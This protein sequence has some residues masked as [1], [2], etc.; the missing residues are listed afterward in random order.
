MPGTGYS[1]YTSFVELGG[2]RVKLDEVRSA[3]AKLPL[4]RVL[5]FLSHLSWSIANQG[6]RIVDPRW[7]APLLNMAIVDDFPTVLPSCAT[8]IAPG[9]VPFTG[10]SNVFIH[11][12]NTAT[13]SHLALLYCEDSSEG[14]NLA[15]S[16]MQ[17]VCRL[18]LIVNDLLYIEFPDKQSPNLSER[19]KICMGWLRLHQFGIE[20]PF[21][22]RAFYSI[23]RQHL[24]YSIAQKN[25]RFDLAGAFERAT[26]GVT[27][28]HTYQ[29]LGLLLATIQTK[30][31]MRAMWL[32]R[33]LLHNARPDEAQIINKLTHRWAC[34]IDAYRRRADELVANSDL[35]ER[36]KYFDLLPLRQSPLIEA[37][38][39]QVICPCLPFVKD[40]AT[41]APYFIVLDSLDDDKEKQRFQTSLTDGFSTYVEGLLDRLALS[42]AGGP[43]AARH[44]IPGRRRGTEIADSILYRKDTALVFEHKGQRPGSRFLSGHSSEL[45]LGPSDGILNDLYSGM[46]VAVNEAKKKDNG[47]LT[48]GMW[49]QSIHGPEIAAWLKEQTGS[50]SVQMYPLHVTLHEPRMDETV[51][52][53]YIDPLIRASGLYSEDY[54]CP[55]QWMLIHDLEAL[56]EISERGE[57]DLLALLERKNRN[58]EDQ[59]MGFDHFLTKEFNS[60]PFERVL[61]EYGKELLSGAVR[62][63]SSPTK[64]AAQEQ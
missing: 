1:A 19:R 23:A 5:S 3:L 26:S 11:N 46:E 43:W 24:I 59:F 61:A 52:G 9:R 15:A 34:T 39:G 31:G 38:N 50:P 51:R 37:R 40:L 33:T 41:D 7:Q 32:P 17:R 10:T 54:W 2:R 53:V 27:L 29:L 49:Q 56:V 25:T 35:P 48:R 58:P 8:Y 64:P 62:F 20:T 30:L 14:G 13:L 44:R 45:V 22:E 12:Q 28:D 21:M 57:L 47:L 16:Q 63:L 55:P 42:D 60:I 18:L 6:V 4:D 36:T